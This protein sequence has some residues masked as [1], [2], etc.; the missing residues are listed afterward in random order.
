MPP[1]V[2]ITNPRQ[3]GVIK[4]ETLAGPAHKLTRSSPK[5]ESQEDRN[6]KG[7]YS[8]N[9]QL[10]VQGLHALGDVCI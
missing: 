9:D 5:S 7:E 8:S 6:P 4:T 3:I 10:F 2:S 1:L